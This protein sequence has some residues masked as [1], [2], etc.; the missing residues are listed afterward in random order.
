M[1]KMKE[2][3]NNDRIVFAGTACFLVKIPGK[4][5]ENDEKIE[6][7]D[8]EFVQTELIDAMDKDNKKIEELKEKERELQGLYNF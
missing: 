1:L 5:S 7:I 6:E 8:W 4:I 3:N 2:L